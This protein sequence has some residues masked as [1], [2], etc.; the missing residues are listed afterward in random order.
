MKYTEVLIIGSGIAGCSAAIKLA[1][2]GRS[3]ILLNRSPDLAESNTNYAQGGIVTLG[4]DDDPAILAQDIINAGDGL[5]NPAAVQ[6][7]V[8]Y[9]PKLVTNFLINQLGVEFSRNASGQLDITLEAAHSKRR[10]LHAD[11]A[12]GAAIE[13]KLVDAVKQS[14]K[15]TVLTNYTAIDL[16]TRPHHSTNPL[17]IYD[18]VTCAGVYALNNSTRSVETIFAEKIILATG[19]IGQLFL[20]TTN[21]EGAR[22]DGIAMAAR[23]GAQLINMEYIQF[24]PTA[25]YH[26]DADRFLISESI[27]GEGAKLCNKSGEYFMTRYDPELADLAPRDVVA[28]AI[29]EEM[30]RRS[31]DHVLLDCSPLK[32]KGIDISDRFPTV[33]QKCLSYGIDA[34]HMPIPVVPAA[35]YF[36]GGIKVD[37]Y[38]RTNIQNLYAIGECSCTG[39]HGANRLASTSLLE[40]LVWATRATED[41]CQHFTVTTN[42]KHSSAN[43]SQHLLN[44]DIPPWQDT[45]LD[46]DV[47]PALIIQDWVTIKTTMWNYAGI[48]RTTKRLERAQADLEYLSHRIEQFYRKTKL[49]DALI[50]LRNGIQVALLIINAAQRNPISRGCHF[51]K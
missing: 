27:R 33:Y 2:A 8:E 47:D 37:T 48:V 19:G 50:G 41:I 4:P 26:K 20:H 12:T 28:R 44:S 3:V 34:Q 15:I 36:C 7:L 11:D 29:H 16:I 5:C 23:A 17:A 31:D 35:H 49:T 1:E 13:K 25:F 14:P 32:S 43:Q 51:R 21:P 18:D 46:E 9:G 6:V 45:G 40:G 38:G 30:L 24:H 39:L 22:G 42:L 10:I